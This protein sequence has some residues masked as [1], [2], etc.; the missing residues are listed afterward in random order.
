VQ[1]RLSNN[2]PQLSGA[3]LCAL[4][5]HAS[6]AQAE[7]LKIRVDWTVVPGQ[8][9]PLIPEVPNYAPNVYRHY[10]K[11]YIVEPLKFEGGGATLTALAVGNTD[12]STLSPQALVL[13]VTNAKLDVRVIGQQISTEVPGY[14]QTYFWAKASKVNTIDDLKGKVIGVN[15]RGSAPDSAAEIM[16]AQHDLKLPNDYQILEVPFPSQLPAL[17]ADKIDVGVLIPPFN[18]EGGADPSLKPIFS[19]GD[20]FGALETSM[21]VSR[22]D[23]IKAHRAALVDFLEDNIRMRRWMTDPETRDD[24]I[25]E[26]SAISKIPAERFQSW[27]YTRND[28]YYDPNAMVDVTRLQRNIDDMKNA[29]LVPEAIKASSYA[30]LSLA[31]EA[32]T[33]AGQ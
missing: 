30:D 23:F 20:V 17:K 24:A 26:L 2:V 31:Q 18:L 21:W 25:K 13:A 1:K 7:P 9:A 29:R 22:A 11:S 4:I 3:I 28:Y 10:G 27:V 15:A 6:V 32:A 19:I 33:R 14:L 12:V 16:L 5:G 8:F